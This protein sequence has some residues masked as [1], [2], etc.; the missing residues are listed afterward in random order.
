MRVAFTLIG[1]KHWLGGTN[2]LL[3]LISALHEAA[4]PIHPVV[5]TGRAVD[6]SQLKPMYE[7]LREPP[8]RSELW[9]SNWKRRFRTLDSLVLQRDSM[10][11]NLFRSR[12]IDVVFQHSAWYGFRF[13]LPTIAWIAD[14]QHRRLPQMFTKSN[15]WKRELG[16]KALSYSATTIM[17]S[18]E[19]AKKD[20]L[21]YYPA[22]AEKIEVLPFAVRDVGIP[23]SYR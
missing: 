5:F 3:N 7:Y 13:S 4:S 1:G 16:Y 19:S 9:D 17:V 22:S 20:C 23:G 10:V 8:V 2:Y 12:G 11:E 15:F 18:S 14:F 6:D 21:E